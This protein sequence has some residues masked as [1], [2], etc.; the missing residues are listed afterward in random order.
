MAVVYEKKDHIATV[1]IDRPE[2]KNALDPETV[3]ALAK[4]WV[5]F[6]DDNDMRVAIVTGTGDSFCSGA[7]LGKLIPL[8]TG[9]RQPE[10][11]ADHAVTSDPTLSQKAL[12]RDFEMPKPV[13]AAVNGFAIAGG[14]ELVQATDIRVASETAR[15][16][17]QEVKW[18]IFPMGGSS[19]R[20]PARCPSAG[21]WRSCCRAT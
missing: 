3:V 4:A 17:L 19:A 20:L 12:L 18:A 13:I 9:A 15:F 5:D 2:A 7:D 16:G 8:I 10:S 6:R 1:R 14:C 11:E 21:R